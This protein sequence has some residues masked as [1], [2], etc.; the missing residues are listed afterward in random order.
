VPQRDS[1]YGEAVRALHAAGGVDRAFA[2]RFGTGP[3]VAGSG[4][5][6]KLTITATSG[7][8]IVDENGG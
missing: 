8:G 3:D 2:G 6:G 5:S 4:F 1:A 7:E